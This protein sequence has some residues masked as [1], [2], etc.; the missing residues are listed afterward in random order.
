MG[1][2]EDWRSPEETARRRDEALRRLMNTP[3]Q[4]RKQERGHD[5]VK[6]RRV[7]GPS[8]KTRTSRD[9]CLGAALTS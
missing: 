2:D 7:G 5:P 9:R 8:R 4:P 6:P 1:E 3:P